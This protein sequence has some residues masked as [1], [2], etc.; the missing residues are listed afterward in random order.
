M[1]VGFVEV[2]HQCPAER[3][4]EQLGAAA[5][6]QHREPPLERSADQCQFPFVAAGLDLAELRMRFLSIQRRV[7]VGSAGHDQ[8]VEAID[9]VD[10]IRVSCQLHR[11]PADSSDPLRILTE[12]QVDFFAVQRPLWKVRHALD[13]PAPPREPY[14]WTPAHAGVTAIG[15]RL[16]PLMKFERSRSATPFGRASLILGSSSSNRTFS[17]MR[18]S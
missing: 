3:D 8:S 17:S 1:R 18:A 10:R 14:Q 4:V 16:M 9:H 2:L 11:K 5:H 12:M 7:G 15:S 6:A 13:G